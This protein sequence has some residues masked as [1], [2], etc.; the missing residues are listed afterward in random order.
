MER[1]EPPISPDSLLEESGFE[2][3]VPPSVGHASRETLS[4][5]AAGKLVPS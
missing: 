5:S 3:V 4:I 1:L 2:L